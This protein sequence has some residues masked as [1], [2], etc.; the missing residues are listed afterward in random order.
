MSPEQ[1]ISPLD[2]SEWYR[3]VDSVR[4]R[5]RDLPVE[6][7]L[8][9][10]TGLLNAARSR[11]GVPAL[12]SNACKSVWQRTL[13]AFPELGKS[14]LSPDPTDLQVAVKPVVQRCLCCDDDSVFR[15][16]LQSHR[17]WF[18][19]ETGQPQQGLVYEATCRNCGAEYR[20]QSFKPPT[21]SAWLAYSAEYAHQEWYVFSR[22]TVISRRLF[23]RF[24]CEFFH[25]QANFEAAVKVHNDFHGLGKAHP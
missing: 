20:V 9:A 10:A 25:L 6:E 24:E 17:A 3:L 7:V 4:R 18:Y 12:L 11:A 22:E 1:V 5:P 15:A 23:R 19:P 8:C 21:S 16:K 13:L 14:K 2:L